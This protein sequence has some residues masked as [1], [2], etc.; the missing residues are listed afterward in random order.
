MKDSCQFFIEL[1]TYLVKNGNMIQSQTEPCLFR[2]VNNTM[3]TGVYVDDMI[4]VGENDSVENVICLMKNRLTM[5]IEDTITKFVGC[6][7]TWS[8]SKKQVLL[9]QFGIIKKLNEQFGEYLDTIGN[10]KTPGAPGSVIKRVID[11]DP[12]LSPSQQSLY[13]SG[14]GSMMYFINHSSTDLSNNVRDLERVM[15]KEHHGHW[16]DLM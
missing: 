9:Q 12:I 13:Q 2:D 7:L 1:K 14:F 15:D 5:T 8:L 6:E 11:G 10:M 3:I 16:N 4:V